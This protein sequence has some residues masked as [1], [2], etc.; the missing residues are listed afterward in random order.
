MAEYLPYKLGQNYVDYIMKQYQTWIDAIF[1]EEKD[2]SNS[3]AVEPFTFTGSTVYNVYGGWADTIG[4]YWVCAQNVN[5]GR[6]CNGDVLSG[7]T[8]L[9]KK[10]SQYNSQQSIVENWVNS[11][12]FVCEM[13]GSYIKSAISNYHW[14]F[15]S[16]NYDTAEINANVYCKKPDGTNVFYGNNP[17]L[18][19]NE[20]A[21]IDS[22]GNV[23]GYVPVLGVYGHVPYDSTLGNPLTNLPSFTTEPS[24]N[25]VLSTDDGY[26]IT[27][28]TT[29]EGDTINI[30]YSSY[31]VNLGSAGFELSYDDLFDIFANV[32][33][34]SL[35][36]E[37]NTIV[38]PT[39]QEIKYSDQ[40]DF[41]IRPLHQYGELPTAP[42]FESEL[43]LADYPSAIG[44]TASAYI[45]FLPASISGL[46][47]GAVIVSAIVSFIR[48]DA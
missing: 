47:A 7:Q 4:F 11:Q 38:V 28:Y 29:N 17:S 24:I 36:A 34:P 22:N 42:T 15:R 16:V 13:W 27:N 35:P 37:Q 48:R 2:N 33:I 1:G 45:D 19:P 3:V 31:G 32:I 25:N 39:Y 21:Y 46:L 41:F 8:V 10:P 43:D 6:N 44:Q 18:D 12:P 40:G 14:Y 9:E 20:G 23:Q 30:K 5:I 26:H